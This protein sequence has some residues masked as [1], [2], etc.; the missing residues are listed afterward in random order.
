MGVVESR[1]A[2]GPEGGSHVAFRVQ[3]VC[4]R[5]TDLVGEMRFPQ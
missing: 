5:D 1:G 3:V 2:K 4:V